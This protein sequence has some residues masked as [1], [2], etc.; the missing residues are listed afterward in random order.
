MDQATLDQIVKVINSVFGLLGAALVAILGWRQWKGGKRHDEIG[1]AAEHIV[2]SA[3]KLVDMKDDEIEKLTKK[4][5]DL[6]KVLSEHD[7]NMKTMRNDR[8]RDRSALVSL[9]EEVSLI[10]IE[11]RRAD[12]ALE[13]L[14]AQTGKSFPEAVETAWRI[15]RGELRL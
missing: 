15:R 10:K 11:L 3:D 5:D 2:S 12:D 7:S 4:L 13:Y 8:D 1:S 14:V 9:T 6:T